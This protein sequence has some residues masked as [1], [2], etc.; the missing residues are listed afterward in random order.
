MADSQDL[1][2]K[3]T[4]ASKE[5]GVR[6]PKARGGLRPPEPGVIG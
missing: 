3:D 2:T 4:K 5:P 6:G 1:T